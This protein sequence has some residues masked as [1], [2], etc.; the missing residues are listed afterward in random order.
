[1]RIAY[2]CNRYPAIS[3]TFILREVRAL[4]KLGVQID[5][6]AIRRAIGGHLL[7]NADRE[8][9]ASTYALLP[10]RPTTLL[11]AHLGAFAMHPLRYLSTFTLALTLRPRGVRGAVWQCFY[12][13]ESMM[14]WRECRRRGITHIHAQF[15]NVATDVALLA[16]HFGA[17]RRGAWSWS[18]T[19]HG[20]VEFYDI[21]Q[22]RL[23]EKL[24]RAKFAICISDFARSQ[25]MAFLDPG[26]WHKLHVVHCG[27]DPSVFHPADEPGRRVQSGGLRILNVGRLIPLKG[28]AELLR[29]LA[30]LRERE[31]DATLTIVGDGPDRAR[32]ESLAAELK[33]TDLVKFA[34]AVGQDEIAGLYGAADVFCMSSFAEGI[35][36]VL[37]EAMAMQVPVVA[38]RIAGIPEL[39]EHG[40][41]GL[42]VSPGRADRLAQALAELALDPARRR[43]MGAA[44]RAKVGAEFDVR[45]SADALRTIF[46]EELGRPRSAD[47][48]A[49]A[50][51]EVKSSG[52]PTRAH[53]A[54]RPP[55]SEQQAA[56]SALR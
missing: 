7:S 14:I 4:R 55:E 19:L 2:L 41:S 5:T 16:A 22:S 53:R 42:I 37:M 3:L 21:S 11:M 28:Q 36:V 23:P 32:L 1:M 40:V 31:V 43:A 6:F 48:H 51:A 56:E 26:E 15:A 35:P 30:A 20:P 24:R 49:R 8:E 50:S 9:F 52:Q 47:R 12:F 27:V 54:H 33:V 10:P 46:S 44:G 45:R 18:F 25:A 34:G 13:A 29:A 17:G 38:T 39:V